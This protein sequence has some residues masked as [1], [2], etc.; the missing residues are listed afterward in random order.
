MWRIE[1]LR[2]ELEEAEETLTVVLAEPR[3][4][5]IGSVSEAQVAI[6][7]TDG[8]REAA[9][10][11]GVWCDPSGWMECFSSHPPANV[12]AGISITFGFVD[13]ICFSLLQGRQRDELVAGA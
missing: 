11:C 12:P 5:A 8:K 1:I 3:G 13:S 6:M 4:A 9:S 2:D 7:E 10:S